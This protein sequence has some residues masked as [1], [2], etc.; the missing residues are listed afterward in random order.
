MTF[1]IDWAPDFVLE[2]VI[3]KLK[4]SNIKSTWFITHDSQIVKKLISEPNIECGIHPNFSNGTTQGKND[5]DVLKKLKKIVPNAVSIRTHGLLQSSSILLKF[6]KYGIKNDVSLFLQEQPNIVPHY[7]KFFQLNRIPFFWEDDVEMYG[8]IE[9]KKFLKLLKI[10]GIKI[11][12]FHPMHIF[13][14]SNNISNY[15]KNKNYINK[16]DAIKI[17]KNKNIG[18]ETIFDLFI[19]NLS[20]MKTET[21]S[22]LIKRY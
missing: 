12:N 16:M 2:Y 21:I 6:N 8:K 7:S 1:D 20:N 4:D 13:L 10:K 11:F 5:E 18:I 14:N 9:P 22:E 3:D 15:Q 19:E 17:L